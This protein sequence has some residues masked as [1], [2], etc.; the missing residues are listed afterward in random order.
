[1]ESDTSFN[2]KYL[3]IIQGNNH[4]FSVEEFKSVYSTYFSS[5]ISIS[6]IKNTLYELQTQEPLPELSHQMYQR[7]TFTDSIFEYIFSA[8]DFSSLLEKM[9]LK[10]HRYMGSFAI[11]QES[12]KTKPNLDNKTLA[13]PIYKKLSHLKVDLKNPTHL[14]YYLFTPENVFFCE[15]LFKNKKEYLRRMPKLRPVAKPY[16]LKSDMARAGI[17]LLEL[18]E[19]EIVLDP[20]CGIGGILLEGADMKLRCIGNDINF[21]DLEHLKTNFEHFRLSLPNLHCKDAQE[22][23][24]KEDSAD[25]IISDIPYGKCSRRLGD[26]LYEKFLQSAQ[27]MLKKDKKMVIIHA[28]FTEFKPIAL[29]YFEE[30]I[31]IEEYINKSMTRY[32]LVLKNSRK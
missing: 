2:F 8:P 4:I 11:T 15:M 6:Q 23:L 25:G 3:I 27:K 17:N 5:K 16:T 32:I 1:M 28:N 21:N 18:K 13:F 12:F 20:F 14:F 30:I 26:D 10:V 19:N 24:L 7:L 31:E 29:K 9:D 22:Q